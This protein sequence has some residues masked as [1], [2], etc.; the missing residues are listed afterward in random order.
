[1]LT[2]ISSGV[3]NT[4]LVESKANSIISKMV[5]VNLQTLVIISKVVIVNLQT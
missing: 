2:T 5:I 1:M 3:L 4:C